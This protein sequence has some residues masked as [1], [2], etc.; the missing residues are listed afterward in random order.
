MKILLTAGPTHEPID[1]VRYIANRSSGKMGLALANAAL[2]AGHVL[3]VVAGP[4][5]LSFPGGANRIDIQT[6]AEMFEAV[7]RE[8]PSHDLLIMAAAV[9]DYRP[10][11]VLPGK[12]ARKGAIA[13][14]CEP[15]V[16]IVAAAS[17]IKRPHQRTVG[18]SLE[19]DND[20][21]RARQKMLAKNL[22]LMVYNP[23]E[24]MGSEMIH[25]ILLY[26]NGTS[27]NL[28]S[29]T[30]DQFADILIQRSVKLF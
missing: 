23:P 12:L 16:D 21:E 7:V 6:A 4:V 8:F 25:A 5:N 10:K 1:A 3:T 11:I 20:I 2:N 17:A 9:A 26:P 24:T 19:A 28:P 13:I 30:K 15:T 18:Y 29:R 27:E 14:E 22:D